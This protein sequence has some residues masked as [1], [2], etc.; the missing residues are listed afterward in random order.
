MYVV[1]PT[2]AS[3]VSSTVSASEDSPEAPSEDK[4]EE[5]LRLR[6]EWELLP[7]SSEFSSDESVS[8]SARNMGHMT[9]NV[10]QKQISGKIFKKT[11]S[12]KVIFGVKAMAPHPIPTLVTKVPVGTYF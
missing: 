3:G 7:P 8:F 9:Q 4:D 10:K 1:L 2:A 11:V 12:W 6:E 5:L